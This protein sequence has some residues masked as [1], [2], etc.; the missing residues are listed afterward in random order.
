[1]IQGD[2]IRLRQVRDGDLERLYDLQEDISNR[3]EFYPVGVFG[4]PAFRDRYQKSGFWEPNEGMLLIVGSDDVILGH[5]EF[6]ETVSY[7]PGVPAG[8]RKGRVH[9]RKRR[10]G[11]VVSPRQQ[12]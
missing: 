8:C 12:S 1:V 11:S 3:G 10:Q 4:W 7:Q 2:Q 9:P 6:F 5:I